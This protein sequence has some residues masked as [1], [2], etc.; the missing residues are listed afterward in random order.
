MFEV[1]ESLSFT[2]ATSSTDTLLL[3]SFLLGV[4]LY[5][6]I[7]YLDIGPPIR[8]PHINPKVAAAIPIVTAPFTPKDSTVAPND[9]AAPCPPSIETAP[10]IIPIK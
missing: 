10:H 6:S 1:K 5:L 7:K 3:T 8:P 2:P 9:A 4:N